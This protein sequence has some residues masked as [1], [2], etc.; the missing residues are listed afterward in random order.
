MRSA[1][2][3]LMVGVNLYLLIGNGQSIQAAPFPDRGVAQT[4]AESTRDSLLYAAREIMQQVRYC[5]LI[6]VG[7]DGYPHAR[8][9]DAFAPDSNFVVWLATNP[10]SRK[11][12]E[13]KSNPNINLFYWE[14]SG[15]SYVSLTGRAKLIDDP[16]KKKRH[17]KAEW[18]QFY[19]DREKGLLL[20]KVIPAQL[21]VVSYRHGIVSKSEDWR[22][23]SFD[24]HTGMR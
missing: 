16:E 17:W 11:V 8:I 12:A 6:T 21:E 15:G 13:I 7:N 5:T 18:E 19:P 1:I 3:M 24:F 20:I 2:V 4:A 22:V 14:E 9:M 23:P 10:R